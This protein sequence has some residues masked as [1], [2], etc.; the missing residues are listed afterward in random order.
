MSFDFTLPKRPNLSALGVD[1]IRFF[2][3]DIGIDHALEW[4]TIY[5]W[6]AVV[7]QFKGRLDISSCAASEIP[8]EETIKPN[9]IR[10]NT[11]TLKT[12]DN[13]SDAAAFFR[14]LRNAFCHYRIHR[15]G[16]FFYM[17]DNNEKRD[18]M[19]GYVDAELLKEF[20]F[21]F[22]DQRERIID[23]IYQERVKDI[24]E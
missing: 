22:F 24:E 11:S 17:T 21:K 23:K 6:G 7:D 1:D 16:E 14:H 20:C 18:T 8:D 12:S 13:K 3:Y 9:T 2:Y 4:P 5:D 10:F 19:R 15:E